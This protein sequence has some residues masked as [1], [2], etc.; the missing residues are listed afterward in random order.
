M[1]VLKIAD[2]NKLIKSFVENISELK[3]ICVE[4]EISN[5]TYQA[6]HMYFTLKD[7]D[8]RIK[9]A[10]FNYNMNDIPR[11]LKEGDKVKVYGKIN[12]YALD[13]S[14]QIVCNK[15]EKDN[16]LGE[17][18]KRREELIALY[19]QK[20]YF[21]E[22]HK[23]PLPKYPK[24]I[25]VV[26]AH[27]G[28]AIHDIINT[29]HKRNP[30]VDIYVYSAKVQGDGSSISVAKGIEYFNNSNLDI[31]CIIIG[32]GGGSIEDLW[33]FNEIE[34]IEAVFKSKIPII[35]AVGHEVDILISDFVADTRAATPTQAAEILIPIKQDL[36]DSLNNENKNS[37]KILI[38]KIENSKKDI[39][40]LKDNYY[41]KEFYSIQIL[42]RINKLED[43]KKSLKKDIVYKLSTNYKK[44]ELNG[45]K[46]KLKD[47]L[48]NKINIKKLELN[49]IKAKIE[50]YD[51]KDMLDRGYTITLKNGKIIKNQ[52]IVKGDTLETIYANKKKLIS[53]VK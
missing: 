6:R 4:G 50:K 15:I 43:I 11:T 7:K 36:L 34:V 8:G 28:A 10:G 13:A 41:L 37:S 29:T 30:N 42:E 40:N 5:L 25:G 2:I 18:Y 33:A 35:S 49:N 31:D 21:N 9:C 48:S 46:N 27:T 45:L 26:T 20:G 52:K 32:R 3:Y 23:K 12:V 1:Q 38:R 22:I 24:C 53:E 14:V 47:M 19:K 17:L 51:I 39:K 16:G 44:D